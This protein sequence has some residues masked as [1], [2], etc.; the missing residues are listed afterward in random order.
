[1]GQLCVKVAGLLVYIHVYE[2]RALAYSLIPT[3]RGL[4]YLPLLATAVLSKRLAPA[5]L[6]L[7]IPIHMLTP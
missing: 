7:L 2:L 3:D 5:L 1:M 6:R 4:I